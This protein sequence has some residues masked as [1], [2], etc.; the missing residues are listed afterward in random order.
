MKM[1]NRQ[2][3]VLIFLLAVVALALVARLFWQRVSRASARQAISVEQHDE[4]ALHRPT[5]SSGCNRLDEQHQSLVNELEAAKALI[6]VTFP[7]EG[8]SSPRTD[9]AQI[10]QLH[11]QFEAIS[12]KLTQHLAIAIYLRESHHES[13]KRLMDIA[14]Q[15]TRDTLAI[16]D[17][18]ALWAST[19]LWNETNVYRMRLDGLTKA[20][21]C[22]RVRGALSAFEASINDCERA[23]MQP[24]S[25][26]DSP[27]VAVFHDRLV[28]Q[29][30]VLDQLVRLHGP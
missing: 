15:I 3:D 1:T 21:Y 19:C 30:A 17:R 6:A 8:P 18:D 28:A 11:K 26:A 14:N 29:F 7:V 12:N 9:Q 25:S 23:A 5:I 4:I 16:D 22:T 10:A 27:G 2:K 13:T 24:S 20:D